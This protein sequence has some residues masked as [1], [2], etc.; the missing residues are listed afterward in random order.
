VALEAQVH[1]TP[2]I[3]SC[4]GGVGEIMQH[5]VTGVLIPPKNTAPPEIDTAAFTEA[6]ISLLEDDCG[7]KV[8]GEQASKIAGERFS[9]STMVSQTVDCY[10]SLL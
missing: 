4:V 5:G 9:Q 3:A 7:C 1:G 6:Q 8:L 10:C 2:V